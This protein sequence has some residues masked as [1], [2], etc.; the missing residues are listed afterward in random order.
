M[1]RFFVFKTFTKDATRIKGVESF[2]RQMIY[3]EY[4]KIL[5]D[6]RKEISRFGFAVGV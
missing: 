2:M 3:A 1:P 6:A 4:K 5:Y